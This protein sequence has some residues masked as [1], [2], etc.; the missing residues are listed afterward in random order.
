MSSRL[1]LYP[2][3]DPLML[4]QQSVPYEELVTQLRAM[5]MIGSDLEYTKHQQYQNRYLIGD[6]FLQY[7]TFMGCAPAIELAPGKDN[8]TDFCHLELSKEDHQ[9]RFIADTVLANPR[10][11]ECK[12]PIKN[13]QEQMAGWEYG[14]T[15]RCSECDVSLQ[16]QKLNWRRAAG[17]V[18]QYITIHGV[19]PKEALPT[20]ALI[21][22]LH[23]TFLFDWD[24]FYVR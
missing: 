2:V 14:R 20:E 15:I 22:K 13:W 12:L 10:C 19:Y 8:G 17:F 16:P 6:H 7:I 3:I 1:I 18:G 23:S 5:G 11:T 21:N 9:L 24:Y 4:E